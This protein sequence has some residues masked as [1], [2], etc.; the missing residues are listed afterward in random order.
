MPQIFVDPDKPLKKQ[1]AETT[2]EGQSTGG[3]ELPVVLP[4][5]R[6]PI[7]PALHCTAAMPCTLR[8]LLVTDRN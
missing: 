8:M 1:L 6:V 4:S 2:Q 7:A 3:G 5:G